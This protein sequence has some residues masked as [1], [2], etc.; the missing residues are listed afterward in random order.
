M[1]TALLFP[2]DDTSQMDLFHRD[3]DDDQ[4]EEQLDETEA[5]W[6]KERIEREQWLREQ[7][8]SLIRKLPVLAK[9]GGQRFSHFSCHINLATCI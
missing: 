5:K 6:R 7:V 2:L 4:V 1:L 8:E 3:S 9:F